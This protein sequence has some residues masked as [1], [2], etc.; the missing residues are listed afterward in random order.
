M[1][2]KAAVRGVRVAV[3]VVPACP[4]GKATNSTHSQC[5]LRAAMRGDY[6]LVLASIWF[7]QPRSLQKPISTIMRVQYFLLKDDGSGCGESGTHL[8]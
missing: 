4:M 1:V 8:A 6:F 2:E 5:L 3:R 7:L